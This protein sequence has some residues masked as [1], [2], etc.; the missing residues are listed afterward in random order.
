MVADERESDPD[1]LSNI[2]DQVSTPIWWGLG[3]AVFTLIVALLASLLLGII[4]FSEGDIGR[5]TG[6][7]SFTSGLATVLL[8]V[9]TGWY[10]LQTSHMVREMKQSREQERQENKLSRRREVNSLRRALYEEISK[11]ENLEEFAENYSTATSIVGFQVPM[12][13]YRANAGKIGLLSEEEA[14]H[15]VEYYARVEIIQDRMELQ[16]ELDTTADMDVV[17]EYFE[18]VQ[19]LFDLLLDV[20]SFGRFGGTGST[21]RAE[22]VSEQIKELAR[23]QDAAL[24]ALVQRLDS[25]PEDLDEKSI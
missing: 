8:V 5:A 25:P 18:R 6:F 1:F 15:V 21:T 2:R 11:I 19:A 3:T 7:A 9:I 10:A 13:V 23:V 12:T 4:A 14:D 16:R 20:V 22:H 17:T 24:S